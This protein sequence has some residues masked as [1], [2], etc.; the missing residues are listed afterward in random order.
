MIRAVLL[1]CLA[2]VACDVD[3]AAP[4]ALRTERMGAT[5]ESTKERSCYTPGVCFTC[6]YGLQLDGSSK[7]QCG[8]KFSAMCPGRE[9]V[10]VHST[11]MRT[12]YDDGSSRRHVETQV[13]GVVEP[14]E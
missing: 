13:V 1:L 12:R 6:W 8:M 3:L 10:A 11:P 7:Q 9:T 2:L 4:H 14:C 5:T